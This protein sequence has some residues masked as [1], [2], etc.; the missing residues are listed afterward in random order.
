M[1][2]EKTNSLIAKA[3]ELRGIRADMIA[4]N[5]ANINTPHFKARDIR[6]EGY[7]QNEAQKLSHGESGV[8]KMAGTHHQHMQGS[9]TSSNGGAELFLRDGH[10]AKNDGNTVDIDVETSE[11][12]KNAIMIQVLSAALKKNSMMM[13]SA[14]D[15]SS[16]L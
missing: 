10:M 8:L 6:F 5:L 14:I 9:S 2:I 13:K 7:L 4:S 11:M 1:Q 15:S 12:S 3:I 16:R